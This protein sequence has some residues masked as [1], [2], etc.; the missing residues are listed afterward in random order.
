MQA[1]SGASSQSESNQPMT[2]SGDNL[3]K[4]EFADENM[5]KQDIVDNRCWKPFEK[6]LYEKGIQIF[7]RNRNLMSGLKSC[8]EIF[9]YMHRSDKK[10]FSLDDNGMALAD[11]CPKVDFNETGGAGTRRRS[12]FVRRRG[13]VCRLKYTWKSA[14]S[15]SYRKRISER[16][17]QP[18]R[19]YSPCGCQ[20]ACVKA[21]PCL[22]NGIGCEKYCDVQ[23]AAR[24]V[25]EAA[26]VLR[27]NVEVVN[28][29]ALLLIESAI[30]MSAEIAG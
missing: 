26:I 19:Q 6:T 28:V 24:I 1:I 3:K 15:Q 8:S 7:G 13:R 18:C 10:I 2:S 25:S 21:C 30:L 20:S 12:R 14:G 4:E 11:G 16:K 27:I 23:R 5:Y 29:H 9:S 22:V 17:D